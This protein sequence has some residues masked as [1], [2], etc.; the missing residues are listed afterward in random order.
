MIRTLLYEVL[1][2]LTGEHGNVSSR[3]IPES[4]AYY[5]C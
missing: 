5:M 1:I 2:I 4:L 3:H